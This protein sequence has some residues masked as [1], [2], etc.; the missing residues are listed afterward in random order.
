S[1]R[2]IVRHYPFD[3][4]KCKFESSSTLLNAIWEICKNGVKY[5]CQEG[6]LD[7]PSREKG[8][9][10]GDLTVTAPAQVYLTGDLRLYKKALIDFAHSTEICPGMMA[11]AP[12]SLM[13][14]IADYSLQWPL[15]LFNF[16]RQSGDQEFLREMYPVAERL[17]TYFQKYR[18]PDGLLENVKDKWNL[19]DWPA[20]LRDGYDFDLAQPVVGDGCHNVINAYYLGAV[21]IINQIRDILNI[22]YEDKVPKLEQAFMN[23]FFNYETGLFVDS[24]AS[25]HSALHSNTIP[26][27]YGLTPQEAVKNVVELIRRKRLNCGV[28]HAYF[29]L[30]GLAKAG[31]YQLVYDLITGEDEHSWA[32][33][34]REGATTCFEVWGKDQKWNTSLCHPWASAPIPILIEDIIGLKPAKPGWEEVS[35]EPH[36]PETL[37]ELTLEITTPKGRIRVEAKDGKVDV[38][39]KEN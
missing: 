15:L 22:R 26:L 23:A 28:H 21:K 19:V 8:Q 33:M 24:T 34:I 17:L 37:R 11:V 16:Y 29:L 10:L 20:N 38:R 31:E 7:C 13:Q 35:F 14:E 39:V 9:Y 32:N 5:G 2:A 25:K 4:G 1:F 12:G 36:L 18:R 3:E 6:Y 27:Y 30:K